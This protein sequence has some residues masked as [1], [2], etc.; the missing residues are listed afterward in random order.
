MISVGA[1]RQCLGAADH[2]LSGRRSSAK[3]NLSWALKDRGG[4]FFWLYRRA[5][6]RRFQRC[7]FRRLDPW[8]QA[9]SRKNTFHP[10]LPFFS[11][12]FCLLCFWSLFWSTLPWCYLHLRRSLCLSRRPRRS[13]RVVQ[14]AQASSKG[15]KT[16]HSVLQ[17]AL[18]LR[19]EE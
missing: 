5:R 13:V 2:W 18:V 3:T 17:C 16:F 4:H 11:L 19:A 15:K 10:N 12:A 9:C 7:R 14:E 6:S 8:P 1:G